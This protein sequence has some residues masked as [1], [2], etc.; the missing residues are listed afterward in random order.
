MHSIR[1]CS[2]LLFS[3]SPGVGTPVAGLMWTCRVPFQTHLLYRN[4]QPSDLVALFL[5][6]LR[7]RLITWNTKHIQ[8]MLLYLSGYARS[9]RYSLKWQTQYRSLWTYPC[10]IMHLH[11]WAHA[12]IDPGNKFVVFAFTSSL[13]STSFFHFH[14]YKCLPICD[15][16]IINYWLTTR[17]S[18]IT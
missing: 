6:R 14:A 11:A 12:S 9:T 10:L 16:Y 17:S 15:S 1:H 18:V 7:C 3:Y 4:H 13:S 2:R 8:Y 5:W